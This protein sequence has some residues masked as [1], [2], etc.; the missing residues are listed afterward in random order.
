[1]GCKYTTLAPYL[2]ELFFYRSVSLVLKT[3]VE[4]CMP[5]IKPLLLRSE[6]KS[7]PS[8]SFAYH[9]KIRSGVGSAGESPP[10]RLYPYTQTTDVMKAKYRNFFFLA[11]IALL[12]LM[13]FSL[14][15]SWGEI[16]AN[17][18]HAGYWLPFN[19]ALWAVIYLMNA[20]SWY[21][22]INDKEHARVSFSYVYRLTISGYVL[23]YVTPLGLLGGEPYRV[24][25]L[26]P[27]VGRAKAASSVILYSMMHVFSHF[28]FWLLGVLLFVVVY[29][30]DLGMGVLLGIIAAVC[31]LVIY[32]FMKGYRSGLVVKTFR[33]LSH[34]PYVSR[35][36]I[37]FYERNAEA[38]HRVD[39]QIAA[40]HAQHKR[41]FYLSLGL[42][43]LARVVSSLE[44]YV[45]MRILT[46]N[47]TVVDSILIMAFSSLFS[48]LMFFMPMQIG[49]REGS[50]ALVADRLH[51]TAGYGL[52]TGLLCR[53][54]ELCWIVI[55]LVLIKIKGKNNG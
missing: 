34:I 36:S 6:R 45:L 43:L 29:P 30:L 48:N 26:A 39:M 49:A 15:M 40:L 37:R 54:R 27:F 20:L 7:G 47:V 11:G 17:V 35:W 2:Q 19:I 33:L 53:V 16:W 10:M 31:L 18:C 3:V 9:N 25:E 41:T 5:Q 24:M 14:D 44:I 22:I 32:F 55:G 8:F 50:I 42:E 28:W 13:L 4:V 51:L 1:M 23:N 21:V 38:L 46:P 52:F 12:M